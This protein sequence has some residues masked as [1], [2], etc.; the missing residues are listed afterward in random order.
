MVACTEGKSR[1][2]YGDRPVQSL[3]FESYFISEIED[4]NGKEDF[5]LFN[6]TFCFSC[7]PNNGACRAL[8]SGGSFI[9]IRR[10]GFGVIS[11]RNL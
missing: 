8:G 5:T 6:E 10:G 4:E 3:L 7:V 9:C 11:D 1:E 2:E